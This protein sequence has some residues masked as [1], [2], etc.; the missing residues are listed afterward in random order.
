M[1]P[2]YDNNPLR[3]AE[4]PMIDAAGAEKLAPEILPRSVQTERGR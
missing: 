2:T 1:W 3:G 4:R